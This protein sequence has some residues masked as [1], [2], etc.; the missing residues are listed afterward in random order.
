[1]KL[2][3]SKNWSQKR[4]QSLLNSFRETIEAADLVGDKSI[5]ID[6]VTDLSLRDLDETFTEVGEWNEIP[7][8]Y[9]LQ[10]DFVRKT[11]RVK[12]V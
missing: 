5:E 4:L 3:T 7:P 10:V 2:I 8:A 1:M 11:A 9:T 12:E 6:F